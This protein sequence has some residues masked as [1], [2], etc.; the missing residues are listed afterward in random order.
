MT[1]AAK[2][3]QVIEEQ[4]ITHRQEI[5]GVAA[6]AASALITPR[7]RAGFIARKA[8]NKGAEYV[9]KME[10]GEKHMPSSSVAGYMCILWPVTEKINIVGQGQNEVLL[11]S[12]F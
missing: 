7:E 4:E 5:W 2:G 6:A 1:A 8:K 3:P 9:R 11:F 12:G 10:S